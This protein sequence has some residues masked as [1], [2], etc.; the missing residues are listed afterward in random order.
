M[1][2]LTPKP[3]KYLRASQTLAGQKERLALF[4]VCQNAPLPASPLFL[5]SSRR[6]SGCPQLISIIKQMQKARHPVTFAKMGAIAKY[7]SPSNN[8]ARFPFL[9]AK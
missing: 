5:L 3:G 4:S 1:G 7:I 6:S 8:V 2:A 9:E